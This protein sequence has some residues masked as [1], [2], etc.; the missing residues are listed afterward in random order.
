MG[1]QPVNGCQERFESARIR[2][3]KPT[4]MSDVRIGLQGINEPDRSIGLLLEEFYRD[5]KDLESDTYRGGKQATRIIMGI[6]DI[7]GAVLD[8]KKYPSV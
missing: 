5:M 6:S 8:G 1:R 3:T 2:I 7:K 4:N